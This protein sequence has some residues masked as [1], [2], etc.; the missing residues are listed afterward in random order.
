MAERRLSAAAEQFLESRIGSLL[1]LEVLLLLRHDPTQWFNAPAVATRLHVSEA[2][3]ERVLEQLGAANLID[4]RIRS[5]LG[6]R[7]APTESAL[8][9]VIDEIAVAHHDDR[10]ALETRLAQR[11]RGAGAAR[12]FAAAFRLPRRTP[13][14]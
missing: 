14:A 8:V 6:F 11:R 10:Q 1:H 5:G 9:P 4:V 12:A 13:R 7:F 2:T 3:A